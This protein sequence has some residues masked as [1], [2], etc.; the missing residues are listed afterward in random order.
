ARSCASWRSWRGHVMSSAEHPEGLRLVG[1]PVDR[2]DGR[3]KVS[4]TATYASDVS[5]PEL[6]HASLVGSTVAAGRML[7][8]STGAAEAAPG[9][10][11]VIT[12]RNA[13]TLRRGPV[14]QP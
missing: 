11:A 2:V 9:V 7:R 4:G 6:A 12:H 3:L 1:P 8:I 5:F 14:C 13:A 10:L